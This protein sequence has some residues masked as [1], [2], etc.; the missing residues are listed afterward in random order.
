MTFGVCITQ[1]ATLESAI[2]TAK[3]EE[4]RLAYSPS[5]GM[6]Q[7]KPRVDISKNGNPSV[8]PIC[9]KSNLNLCIIYSLN[10]AGLLNGEQ[11]PLIQPWHQKQ[12]NHKYNNNS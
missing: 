2:M 11:R 8:L 1:P 4:T 6:M 12:G 3:Q 10:V 5:P 9:I 7:Y